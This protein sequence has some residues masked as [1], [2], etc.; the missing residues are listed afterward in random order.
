[1][2]LKSMK[3]PPSEKEPEPET[4]IAPREDYPWGLRLHLDAQQLEQLGIKD[5]PDVGL[6]VQL[7]AKAKVTS[8]NMGASEGTKKV[9]KSVSLQ[10]T[11]LG[12]DTEKPRKKTESVFYGDEE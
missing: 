3:L 8:V 12:L 7:V 11:D 4:A 5:L 10:I 6:E 2:E 9:H 1:M